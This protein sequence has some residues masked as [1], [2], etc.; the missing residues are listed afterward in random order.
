VATAVIGL[1]LSMKSCRWYR[2]AYEAAH[3]ATL[4][5]LRV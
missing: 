3:D 1:F 2:S 5:M 4:I